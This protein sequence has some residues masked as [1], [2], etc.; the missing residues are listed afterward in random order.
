MP[1]GLDAHSLQSDDAVNPATS[2]TIMSNPL[3]AI[4]TL[5]FQ[6]PAFDKI[7]DLDYQPAIEEGMKRHLSEISAITSNPDAPTFE[8]TFVAMEK[9]GAMLARVT[10]VFEG[11]TQANISDSLQKV[12][13]DVA[14]KLV[15][16]RDAIKLNDEL[17]ARLESLYK[18]RS[19]LK[20]DPESLRLVEVTYKDFVHNGARLSALNKAKLQDLNQE[21][22]LLST[23]FAS[24]LLAATNACALLVDDRAKL[25]GL[26]DA[27]IAAAANAANAANAAKQLG[28]DCKWVLALHN[29][30]QQPVLQDLN[31]RAIREVLYAS[32]VNRA[33]HGDANDTRDI[34]KR[35][36]QIRAA[37]AKLL[38]FPSYAAWKLNDQM[39]KGPN[40]V[41]KF[42]RELVPSATACATR[43]AREIQAVIELQHAG[44]TVEAWDWE[45]Y[46]KQV[47]SAKF[48]LDE[49]ETKPYFE[50][51]SVL[52][53]G[54]FFAANELYGI[55]LIER[56]DIPVYQP[57]V[58][59]F[60]VL[61]KNNES[62]ALFYCDYFK[63]SNKSGGA[64]MGNFVNQSLL[65]GAKPVIYNVANFTKPA[66]GRPALLS[67]DDVITMFHEFGHALHGIFA[68]TKY[69][70]LSG[71]NTARDFVEF[72]SQLNEHWATDP[73]VFANYAKNYETGEAMPQVLV[74]KM[75]TAATFG[76]GY[77]M[78][79][80]LS[81][82]LLDMAWHTLA[83][84]T[85]EQDVSA[86]ET[87]ILTG[88]KI[89]LSCVPPRYRSSYFQHIWS[90]GYAAGYYAYLWTEV[91]A[92]DGFE[93]FA[94]HGGL[95]RA[96]GDR[97]RSMV[98]SRGNTEDL[99][100][101]YKE[102]RGR[103]PS[104][105]PMLS[106]RGL[107]IATTEK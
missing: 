18:R 64:W 50:L 46:S 103:E 1:L 97:F 44:F 21:E 76:K 8:N 89:D 92:D 58:R 101:L 43:E 29:T 78:T 71:T 27:D 73:K 80:L 99:N 55:T 84:D 47:R 19:A 42:L 22:A 28:L 34:I 38:G 49:S 24:K 81:A 75:R 67:F 33:E 106:N 79:E 65:T 68:N 32:S 90:D 40:A 41:L 63:R 57:D 107:E 5:P 69:P 11:V 2:A 86:L 93:W 10:M 88:G 16:H 60:E 96:N 39:A 61:D 77:A 4:S 13:E 31:D 66:E 53:N 15:A 20:L 98:L 9:S 51:E 59:V 72:P 12:R 62:M 23:Q 35:I 85:L 70:S 45:Y 14:P 52:N 102:W 56:M 82:A 105:K 95:K 30:T 104:I 36:A 100:T 17:F 26:S 94:Q 54:V 83:D 25:D 3:Y 48:E 91:L 7:S 87:L 74:D 37:Q 6:A